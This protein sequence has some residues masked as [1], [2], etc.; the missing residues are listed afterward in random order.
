MHGIKRLREEP[1]RFPAGLARRGMPEAVDE[2]LAA[3]EN[4]RKLTTRVEELR[5]TQNQASKAIG[6]AEGD[7]KQ[8]LIAEV[9]GVS[10]E[11]KELEPQLADAE[12]MLNGLLASTPNLPDPSAPDGGED[13]AVEIKRNH[14][15]PPVFDFEVRDH[16]ALGELLGMLDTERG[17]RTSGSRFV[18][19]LG[20]IVLL[21]FALVRNAMDILMQE[22][23]TPVIPPV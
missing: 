1:E 13:D 18:Y 11:L 8:R 17:A 22:D 7:E 19:L 3:D 23:F 5:A 9:A 21:Q 20:D 12:A 16:A 14:D 4:R 2:L 15:R 6:K 10:A